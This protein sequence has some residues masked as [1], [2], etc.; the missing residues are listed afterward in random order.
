MTSSKTDDDRV[1]ASGGSAMKLTLGLLPMIALAGPFADQAFAQSTTPVELDPISVDG[2]TGGTGY[3]TARLKSKKATAPLINTPQTVTVVPQS[4]IEER[5]ATDLVEVLRNTPGI[6]ID[7]GENGFSSGGNSVFI[8]GM[9][10]TGSVFVDGARDNGNYTRDTFNVEAVEVVKGPAADNG[11]GGG[12]G[13]VNLVTKTP[14]L[15][16]FIRASAVAGFDDDGRSRVRSQ[17]DVNQVVD[18]FAF[19]FNAMA[20][21]GDIFGRDVADSKAWG[22]APSLAYGL[23]TDFRAILA[24]EH[25]ERDELPDSGIAFNRNP[26]ENRTSVINIPGAGPRD[27]WGEFLPRDTFFG[28]PTD[29]NDSTSDAFLARFEYDLN[30]SWTISNQTRFQ[31]VDRESVYRIPS[32]TAVLPLPPDSPAGRQYYERVND[33]L[34]NLTNISGEVDFGGFKHSLSGGLEL[35]SEASDAV[36]GGD[37]SN[38]NSVEINTVA[39]YLYDTVELSEKWLVNGGFRVERYDVDI[40]SSVPDIPG[41]TGNSFSQSDTTV[42]GKIGVVYKPR[43]EGSIYASYGVSQMPH[44]SLMSNP[45]ISRTGANAFPGFV[46]GADPVEAHNYEVGVK[47]DFFDG[48]LSTS[49]ALFHTNKKKVAYNGAAGDPAIVYGEQVIQG[50]EFGFSGDITPRW[51]VFGGLLLLD[52]E[53]KHGAAVDRALVSDYGTTGVIHP[54]YTGV[55]STNGDELAFTPDVSASLWTKYRWD[56]GLTLGGGVQYVGESWIGRPDDAL[57]VIPNG[58]FGKLPDHF[59]VHLMATYEV[60]DNITVRFNV[61]NVFDEQY[62]STA[63]WNGSWGYLGAPRTYRIGSSFKF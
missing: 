36:R 51:S 52:T 23:G 14:Q 40:E 9:N 18:S 7:A 63:N 45:D 6:S 47:W 44:G 19:R 20:E 43:P 54:G 4:V 33:T 31:R 39:A 15:E 16:E 57:R 5:N 30:E 50:A 37:S 48:A 13:Y 49:A 53:R 32:A 28:A 2:G 17:V 22:V 41:T 56:N 24:Y 58:K 12:S 26:G 11:R 35:S 46:A 42:G 38:V 29:Y 10:A 1:S 62:L 21:G 61:D 55:T 8:R 3:K 59:L 60:N 27:S 25:V 34:T